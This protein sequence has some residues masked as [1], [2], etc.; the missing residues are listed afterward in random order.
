MAETYRVRQDLSQ[1]QHLEGLPLGTVGGLKVEHTFPLDGQDQ[2]RIRL[3]RCH[4]PV[5]MFDGWVP[6]PVSHPYPTVGNCRTEPTVEG[7]PG[8]PAAGLPDCERP[9]GDSNDNASTTSSG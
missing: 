2:F 7:N 9:I 6:G 3:Q 5:A 4:V 8:V 1:N